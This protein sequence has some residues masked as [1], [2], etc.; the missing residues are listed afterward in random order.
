M[1]LLLAHLALQ[2]V[3]LGSVEQ[4]QL[5]EPVAI[6]QHLEH[7]IVKYGSLT[8]QSCVEVARVDPLLVW[9]HVCHYQLESALHSYNT[10]R[11]N[12]T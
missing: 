12:K 3:W 11:T 8:P 2:S 6:T 9:Q 7:H 1:S 10:A 5:A 4:L